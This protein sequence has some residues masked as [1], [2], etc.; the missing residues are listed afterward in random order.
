MKLMIV[1]AGPTSL[2][3]APAYVIGTLADYADL[4]VPALLLE[5]RTHAMTYQDGRLNVFSRALWG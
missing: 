5:D 1:C 4:D 2:G 3:I